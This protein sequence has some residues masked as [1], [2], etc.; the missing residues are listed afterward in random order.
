MDW[1]EKVTE[2]RRV[3]GT[4]W[5]YF[6]GTVTLPKGLEFVC[7]PSWSTC[8]ISIAIFIYC[9]FSHLLDWRS[10]QKLLFSTSWRR[11]QGERRRRGVLGLTGELLPLMT[12]QTAT[13]V[14]LSQPLSLTK[15]ICSNTFLQVSRGKTLSWK[16]TKSKHIHGPINQKHQP[17][18]VPFLNSMHYSLNG[19]RA[20]KFV[21][22]K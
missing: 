4:L 3:Q 19:S 7:S 17:S 11:L 9:P 6:S 15:K 21:L 16:L 2:G 18:K 1:D 10:K 12:G 20:S 8:S 5:Q 13:C 22:K 14:L